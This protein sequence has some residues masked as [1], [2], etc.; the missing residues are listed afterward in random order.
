MFAPAIAFVDLET[1]GTTPSGDRIT[2]IGIVRV[3]EGEFA[4][5][6]STLVNPECSIPEE[7]RILTGISNEMVRDAP[8]FAQLRREVL[9]RLEGHLFVAHN[10][11]FDYGFIKNEFR[12]LGRPFSAEVL[13][14]VRLSRKLFPEHRHH[15]LDAIVDRHRLSGADRHRALGDARLVW[16]FVQTLYRER[17]TEEIEAAVRQL[18]KTPSLPPQ[19]PADALK[20]L[21]EGPGVYLFYGVNELPLY[22]GKSKNLRERVRS[23]FSSDHLSGNDLRLSSE[24]T[25]IEF[26][27]TAGELGAL[28]REAQ[29]IKTL[30]PQHNYR[31]RRR[32][33]LCA[34][35]LPEEP[36]PL[37]LVVQTRF[38]PEEID[39]LHGPFSSR[40]AV[41][42]L[43]TDLAAEHGLCWSRL[44]L[45]KRKGPCFARQLGHCRGACVGAESQADHHARLRRA[46]LPH[47][48]SPWP[49]AGPIG[50]REACE[51]N[52]REELHLVDRWCHLGTAR[53]EHEVSELLA[54]SPPQ[55]FD[56]D[57]YR[58]V[59]GFLAKPG[60]STKILQF[61]VL[62]AAA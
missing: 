29:L 5:E 31:L 55:G 3:E 6:W 8:T 22:I 1:T 57:I 17:P 46:L 27:E 25:H 12:R 28:L 4:D 19:L 21:P 52:G 18:L 35:R 34:L 33:G 37:E 11:R 15:G 47:C 26:E 56:L 42:N 2:E 23:H 16:E 38:T 36:G 43:L 20:P 45:E 58:I 40:R 54:S 13:C 39:G 61:P 49:F 62:K 9:E 48:I 51:E 30:L 10:A 41:K 59:G 32:V 50:I 44:G 60:A 24:V 7:I 14:T 53:A